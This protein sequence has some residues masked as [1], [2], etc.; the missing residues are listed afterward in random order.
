M[1][2]KIWSQ[3][4][5][6]YYMIYIFISLKISYIKKSY[7]KLFIIKILSYIKQK[8]VSFI[9]FILSIYFVIFENIFEKNKKQYSTC[10]GMVIAVANDPIKI[11][12]IKNVKKYKKVSIILYYLHSIFSIIKTKKNNNSDPLFI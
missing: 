12:I 10:T 11:K 3:I 4:R 1:F 9:M 6:V 8:I 2:S 7:K 5:I